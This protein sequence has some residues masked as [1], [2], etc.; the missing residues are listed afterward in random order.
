ML[1]AAKQLG[2]PI[3]EKLA[4]MYLLLEETKQSMAAIKLWFQKYVPETGTHPSEEDTLICNALLRDTI[5]Q[6][7]GCFDKT[8]VY[9]LDEK[10]VFQ[11][12]EG[13]AEYI[14]W[15]KDIRDSYAAHKFGPLRQCV[16]GI[17]VGEDGKINGI[18]YLAQYGYPFDETQEQ[19]MLRCINTVH[20]YLGTKIKG[21]EE[22]LT[23]EAQALEPEELLNLPNARTY[24]LSSSEIRTSRKKL[25][26]TRRNTDK[27]T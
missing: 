11:H 12:I 17:M 14:Q 27:K 6:F 10:E 26:N 19:Q 3:E 9:A 8:T 1:I 13:G 5:I 15:L 22:R 21:L 23:A 20:Q 25:Q 24:G 7:V 2:S 18:S 4:E 16:A